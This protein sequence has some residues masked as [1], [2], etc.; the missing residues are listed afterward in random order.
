MLRVQVEKKREGEG[1]SG[2]C[3]PTHSALAL[4]L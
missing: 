1:L 3:G 4:Q 2:S